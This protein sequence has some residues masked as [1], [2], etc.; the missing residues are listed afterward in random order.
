MHEMENV[1]SHPTTNILTTFYLYEIYKFATSV[2][3][4]SKL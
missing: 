3:T 2:G 4:T 1:K